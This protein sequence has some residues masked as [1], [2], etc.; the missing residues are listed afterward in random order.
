VDYAARHYDCSFQN[1]VTNNENIRSA[2]IYIVLWL[3]VA[4]EIII[5]LCIG[6]MIGLYMAK[7]NYGKL[8]LTLITI[9]NITKFIIFVIS[10]SMNSKCLGTLSTEHF[11]LLTFFCIDVLVIGISEIIVSTMLIINQP[12]SPLP[13]ENRYINNMSV[14]NEV[15]NGRIN[16]YIAADLMNREPLISANANESL[17]TMP[18]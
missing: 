11:Y 6:I 8:P 13:S 17:I 4:A 3:Y 2:T 15:D 10:I 16:R 7:N 1:N 5:F 12:N 14:E 18:A 9:L